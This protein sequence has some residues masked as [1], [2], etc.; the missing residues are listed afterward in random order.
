MTF[1]EA[2]G[3]RAGMPGPI[4]QQARVNSNSGAAELIVSGSAGVLSISG[5][6]IG[7]KLGRDGGVNPLVKGGRLGEAERGDF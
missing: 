6:G 2:G 7:S 1:S 4:V 3:G 5:D